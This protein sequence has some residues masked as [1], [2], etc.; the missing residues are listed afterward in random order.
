MEE[1]EAAAEQGP[2]WSAL[3]PDVI[4]QIQVEARKKETQGFCKLY[5]WEELKSNLPKKLKLSPLAM[6]PLKSKN[7]RAI[8]DLSFE[9]M[10]AGYTLPLINEATELMAPAEAMDQIGTVLPRIIEALASAPIEEGPVMFSKLDIRDGFWTM[11]CA[12]GED[13]NFAYVLP[14]NPGKPIQIVVPSELQMGWAELPPFFCAA[15]ETESDVAET[16][17]SERVG[18]LPDHPL[19]E[20]TMP[21][22][23]EIDARMPIVAA[24]NRKEKT[25]FL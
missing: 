10:L 19:E 17:T 18:T 6:I 3:E 8:L 21:K 25:T 1:L 20:E 15:L 22:D 2:H 5:D 23:A 13:W 12:E 14:N 11:T 4:A 9:L 7:Y 16:Y 24:M